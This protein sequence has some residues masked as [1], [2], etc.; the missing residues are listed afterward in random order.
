MSAFG[1]LHAIATSPLY[2][3]IIAAVVMYVWLYLQKSRDKTSLI[4]NS[5]MTR[6]AAFVGFLVGGFVFLASRREDFTEKFMVGS[7]DT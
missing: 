5:M 4:S 2:G 6:N 1:Q 7:L 3:G